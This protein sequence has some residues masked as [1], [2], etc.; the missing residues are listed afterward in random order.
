MGRWDAVE[1]VL[2]DGVASG[3]VPQVVAVVADRDGVLFEA[4]FGSYAGA[5][6]SGERAPARPGAQGDPGAAAPVDGRS[7][8]AVMS[9]TK[10]VCTTVALAQR[11]RGLLDFGAPVADYCP[12][13][14]D[15]LVLD[16]FDG[17]VPRMRR[18]VVAATVRQLVTHTAGLAYWFWDKDLARYERVTG[19]PNVASGSPASFGAPLVADPGTRFTYGIATDWLGRVVEAVA[20]TTLDVAVQDTVTG[21]LG[22]SDTGFRLTPE[23]HDRAVPVHV[24]TASGGWRARPSQA[25]YQPQWYSGGHGLWSTPRDYTR[26]QRMLL[27][28]GEL[29]GERV[30][31]ES[32]VQEAFSPQ[33]GQLTFPERIETSAPRAA[34]TLEL[35]PGWTWGL[36]ML[37]AATDRP[38][39]RRA[40]AGGWSGLYNTH[41]W[42]DRGAGITAS[43]YSSCVPFA[44]RHT[45]WRLYEDVEA[46]VYAAG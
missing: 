26:F 36:G 34:D 46:A 5:S 4:G 9:M 7:V 12:E 14:G 15:L 17:A 24:P 31:A 25:A 38:G 1:A 37:L 41:F 30:L 16:G 2:R 42:V 44:A 28:G 21:P 43:L 20:G 10:M 39:R 32:T 33:L 23:Q 35:G 19:L 3:A 13:F 18:P 29:G 22:M 11:D 27:R 45:A 8:F 40:G 6:P